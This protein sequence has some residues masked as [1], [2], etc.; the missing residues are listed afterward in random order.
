[1]FT[2]SDI[3]ICSILLS[4]ETYGIEELLFMEDFK[5]LAKRHLY[6]GPNNELSDEKANLMRQNCLDALYQ[7]HKISAAY[8]QQAVYT[9]YSTEQYF[10]VSLTELAEH[11]PQLLKML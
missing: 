2:A 8:P 10:S 11:P 3:A 6:R 7:M 4:V 1:M 9:K 5:S